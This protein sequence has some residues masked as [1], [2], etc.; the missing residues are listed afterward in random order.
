MI[1][2]TQIQQPDTLRM[3]FLHFIVFKFQFSK[4]YPS[5]FLPNPKIQTKFTILASTINH[6][7]KENPSLSS[8]PEPLYCCRFATTVE[9]IKDINFVDSETPTVARIRSQQKTKR[10]LPSPVHLR[11]MLTKDFPSVYAMP[12]P[13]LRDACSVFLVTWWSGLLRSTWMTSR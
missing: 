6:L 1:F 3:L 10:R 12:L 7:C 13:H 2:R 9:E 4:Q 8:T 5:L 11:L